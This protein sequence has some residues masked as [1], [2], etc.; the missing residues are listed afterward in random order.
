MFCLSPERFRQADWN[1]A[2][3]IPLLQAE[4]NLP[5]KTVVFHE[6]DEPRVVLPEIYLVKECERI[7][8]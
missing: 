1:K 2:T 7:S 4:K 5:L 8:F 6:A 3:K